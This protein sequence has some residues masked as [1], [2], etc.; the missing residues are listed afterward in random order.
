M[1][2]TGAVTDAYH[3]ITIANPARAFTLAEP[4]P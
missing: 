1:R 3:A 4:R 2:V